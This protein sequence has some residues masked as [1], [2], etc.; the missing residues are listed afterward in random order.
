MIARV[1]IILIIS[2]ILESIGVV[3]LSKGIKQIGEPASISATEIARI[4]KRG[5]ANPNVLLGVFFEA[6]FFAGFLM[7]LSQSDVSFIWPLTSLSFVVTTLA[8]KFILHEQ[9]SGVRW[10]GVACI[11][12]GA[13]LISYS[14]HSKP[15]IEAEP[16]ASPAA[17]P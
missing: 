17:K 11:M 15:K 16:T 5:V 2:L 3:L 7:M 9:V 8:A 1:F 6:L 14:E 10:M 4:I 12:I 13:A